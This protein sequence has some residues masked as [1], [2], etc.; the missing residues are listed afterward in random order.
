M[1]N[2]GSSLG[3]EE[4]IPKDAFRYNTETRGDMEFP[5]LLERVSQLTLFKPF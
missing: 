5:P 2:L 3:A 4:G 1:S